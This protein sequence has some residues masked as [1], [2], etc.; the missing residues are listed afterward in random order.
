MCYKRRRAEACVRNPVLE[1]RVRLFSLVPLVWEL[2]PKLLSRVAGARP[3][4]QPIGGSDPNHQ[5]IWSPPRA[6]RQRGALH[7]GKKHSDH[8]APG[9]GL[10]LAPVC[11]E[12]LIGKQKKPILF[13]VVTVTVRF[14]VKLRPEMFPGIEALPVLPGISRL[15][16]VP[17]YQ[18]SHRP[19]NN[20]QCSCSAV[21]RPLGQRWILGA[22]LRV[23]GPGTPPFGAR[24]RS[25][26]WYGTRLGDLKENWF[27]L[28]SN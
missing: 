18:E 8:P 14:L 9:P 23:G 4:H 16:P 5:G 17:F 2:N 19:R 15:A 13:K 11:V 20:T 24:G 10:R 12:C 6:V 27:L 22:G 28:F 25:S 21:G 26:V 7:R 1:H 3:D